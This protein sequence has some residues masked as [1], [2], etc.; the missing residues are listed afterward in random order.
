MS[1]WNSEIA[2]FEN[3]GKYNHIFMGAN[4]SIYN[5]QLDDILEIRKKHIVRSKKEK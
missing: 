1:Y 3:K 5:V 2:L 4:G